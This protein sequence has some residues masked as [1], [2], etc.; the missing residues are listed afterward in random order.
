MHKENG[1]LRLR[2]KRGGRDWWSWKDSMKGTKEIL[3]YM[4]SGKALQLR[5]RLLKPT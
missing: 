3:Y 1:L 2:T 5:V 4:R